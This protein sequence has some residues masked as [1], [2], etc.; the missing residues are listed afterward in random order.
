MAP[1]RDSKVL[2]LSGKD[3]IKQAQEIIFS[4]GTS[5]AMSEEDTLKVRELLQKVWQEGA[6]NYTQLSESLRVTVEEVRRLIDDPIT[7]PQVGI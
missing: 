4:Y 3:L 2:E 7:R 6:Y 5:D 1:K